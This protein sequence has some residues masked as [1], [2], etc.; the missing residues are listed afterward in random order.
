MCATC[1]AHF[2]L[3]DVTNSWQTVTVI[4]LHIMQFCPPNTPILPPVPCCQTPSVYD[5]SLIWSWNVPIGFNKSQVHVWTISVPYNISSINLLWDMCFGTNC[6]PDLEKNLDWDGWKMLREI[7]RR[8]S[9]RDD[10]R[11]QLRRKNGRPW[12]RGPKFSDGCRAKSR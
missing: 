12:W 2:I 11:R 5:P 9:L 8:C 4:K 3:P 7:C 6:K 1:P 10:D